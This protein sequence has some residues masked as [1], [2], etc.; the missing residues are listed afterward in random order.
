M[1]NGTKNM[2]ITVGIVVAVL[3]G[4][5]YGCYKTS[6]NG[7]VAKDEAVQSAW[8]QVQNQYQRRM[9]LIPNLVNTVKGYATHEERVFTEIAEARAQAGGVV[10]VDGAMLDDP[11][12]FRKY[13]Q[14]QDSLGASLQRLL[15]VTENYPALQANEQFVA[16]MDNLE[17]TENRISVERK[18]YNEAVQGYNTFIREFPR[19]IIANMSGF[20]AKSYFTA[21]EAAQTAP[22]VQF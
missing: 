3:F 22:S 2:L 15:A 17:G 14:V 1:K 19:S 11:E 20:R 6:Y 10:R 4:G 9:D 18:R 16:L 8:A 12:Q 7:M 5:G 13:Q 21:A